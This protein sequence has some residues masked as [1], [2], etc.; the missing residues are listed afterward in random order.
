[1]LP[2]KSEDQG[3]DPEFASPGAVREARLGVEQDLA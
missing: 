1:M 3:S 2:L